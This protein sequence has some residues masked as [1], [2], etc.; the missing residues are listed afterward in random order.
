[1]VI[2]LP[3]WF[4]STIL[5]MC[6]VANAAGNAAIIAR[7]SGVQLANMDPSVSPAHDLFSYANGRWLRDVA[8]PA[9]RSH[10]GVDTIMQDN[11]LH[12]E[13][14][15]LVDATKAADADERKAAALY[16]AYMDDA[17][18]EE[19]GLSPIGQQ[20][21]EID[22]M[23]SL[24][25]FSAVMGLF[26]QIGVTVPVEVYVQ[27]DAKQ[28][29]QYAL[30]LTQG[31]LGLPDRDYYLNV[32]SR[33]SELRDTYRRHIVKLL[34]WAGDSTAEKSAANV[35]AFET[36]IAKL[37]WAVVDRRDPNK[38][39]N[40][41]TVSEIQRGAAEL[42]WSSFI[43]SM[44]VDPATT[45]LILRQ[46]S[47]AENLSKLLA[48]TPLPTLRSYLALRLLSE[49]AEFL[50]R[51]F[52]EEHFAFDE[53]VLHGTPNAPDR[54]KRACVLVDRQMGDALG[55]LYVA[56]YFPERAKRRADA[57]VANL[58]AAYA[59]SI[60]HLQWLTPAT[61]LEALAK[62]RM[63]DVRIGYPAHW[64]SYE[65]LEIRSRDLGGNVLRARIFESER[66]FAK[67]LGP[68]DRSEWEMTAPTVDAGYTP[69][70]NSIEFPAG[71]LQPPLFDPDADDA[72]NYG[73]T[74]ATIGHEISHAFDNRGSQYDGNGALRDWWTARDH[75]A[76][77]AKTD[78][79]VSQFDQYEPVHGFH[80]NGKLTLP[81]N[82]ADLAGLEIAYEA[83]VTSLQG[84]EAPI[85]D[86]LTG[87]QR[88]FIGYAQS[89][90]GKRRD[91][92]LVAQLAS[93]PHA[94]ERDR[95]NGIVVHMDAFYK[96][97]NVQPADT[98]YLPPVQRIALW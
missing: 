67:L 50:P 42:D 84:R 64:R 56:H 96:A 80:V 75:D 97:F 13:R 26:A 49:Y 94:P 60:D 14:E 65:R 51:R 28:P 71:V 62:L 15:L 77:K 27:P 11:A 89:F 17:A 29:S 45:R 79:L 69:G 57:M 93:N 34:A 76:F 12:Q 54:W 91:A 63:I 4:L 41:R 37:Q 18:I 9:D 2:R 88:F 5:M 87:P 32:D 70:T 73:S 19:A 39:Y 66:Q 25:D 59:T 30:W 82:I 55:K 92:L 48:S 72:Y 16:A 90:M 3:T 35:L 58:L 95:V 21:R 81:E 40:P 1:M 85:I 98:M 43:T 33:F 6:N 47:Y 53:G 83:Y 10:Y 44:G 36:E 23:R 46:P 38:T 24:K 20:L 78:L 31:G 68:V 61:R 52:A 8:I 74:G 7:S 86:G 22:A